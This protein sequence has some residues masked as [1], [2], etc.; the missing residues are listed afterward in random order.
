LVTRFFYPPFLFY[1]LLS[2][3]N[4]P[5]EEVQ[6]VPNLGSNVVTPATVPF[7]T[8]CN[9]ISSTCGVLAR[10]VTISSLPLLVRA[11]LPTTTCHTK[12][13]F[14]RTTI[15]GCECSGHYIYNFNHHNSFYSY[16][17]FLSTTDLDDE[18]NRCLIIYDLEYAI[19][20]QQFSFHC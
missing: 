5:L 7:L 6:V 9:L 1:F 3:I 20:L 4:S 12:R 8:F 18:H 14:S 10:L 15:E 17:T 13:C 2:F 11:A 19:F 16:F